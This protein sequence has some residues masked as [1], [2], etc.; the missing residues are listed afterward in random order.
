MHWKR[1]HPTVDPNR[2]RSRLRSMNDAFDDA[3]VT[4]WEPLTAGIHLPDPKDAHVVAAALVGRADVIVTQ[5]TKDFP[6]RVLKPLGLDV[7]RVDEFLLDQFDLSPASA[8]RIVNEQAAAMKR[9]PVSTGQ[10]LD[11]LARSGAPIFARRVEMEFERE[12]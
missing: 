1:V 5:N 12:A 9:P 8:C 10:L 4:G 2:F 7:V 3:L 11:R 6:D